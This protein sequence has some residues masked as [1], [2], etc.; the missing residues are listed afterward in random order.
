MT[1]PQMIAPAWREQDMPPECP[2]C[3]G[4]PDH[5]PVA[6][7]EPGQPVKPTPT[8]K[9]AP[10]AIKRD[11]SDLPPADGLTPDPSPRFIG[12]L[13]PPR[14]CS[15]MTAL[16]RRPG[17]LNCPRGPPGISSALRVFHRENTPT[18]PSLPP[19]LKIPFST[20]GVG[21]SNVFSAWM[22]CAFAA[23]FAV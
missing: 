12:V 1:H 6:C 17:A 4:K 8:P 15:R 10:V 20:Y 7:T 14:D 2:A 11:L 5:H 3:G 9:E 21:R 19:G 23:M 18:N 13:V 16:T 22:R